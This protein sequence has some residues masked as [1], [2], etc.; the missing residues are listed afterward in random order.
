MPRFEVNDVA[1]LPPNHTALFKHACRLVVLRK[2]IV[3]REV[4]TIPFNNKTIWN[5][6]HLLE[7]VHGWTGTHVV[8]EAVLIKVIWTFTGFVNKPSEWL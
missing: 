5:V 3:R 2:L 4:E 7:F 1:R 6:T 8:D